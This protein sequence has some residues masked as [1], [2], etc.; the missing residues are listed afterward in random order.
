MTGYRTPS[1]LTGFAL[2]A[3]LMAGSSPAHAG[4]PLSTEDAGVNPQAQCQLESWVDSAATERTVHVAPA[5]G[6]FDGLEVGLEWV[7]MSPRTELR[8]AHAG[9]LKWAPD[10]LA[11]GDWRFGAKV[12]SSHEK[13]AD[14]VHAHQVSTL[15]LGIASYVISP[16][17]TLHLNVGHERDKQVHTS[18]TTYGSAVAWTPDDRWLV[19]GEITGHTDA[20]ATQTL[21]LRWWLLPEQLGLD[22]TA[23]R[24]NATAASRTWGI[25]L[26]WYGIKF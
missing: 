25:G 18:S 21:G 9:A 6:V 4:R 3:T 2:A 7:H 20:P 19:F 23:S 17:W 14:E 15:V 24:T 11:L 5:C 8:H 13:A 22:L 12:A 16:Q 1:A 10:W 26:G